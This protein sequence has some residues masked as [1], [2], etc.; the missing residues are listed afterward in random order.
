MNTTNPKKPLFKKVL[1][2]TI[3]TVLVLLVVLI[4]VPFLFKDKIVEMVKS[5]ANNNINA[6][7]TFNET[8]L[9]LLRNF[10]NASLRINNLA[11]INKAPF[12]GDTLFYSEKLDLNLKITE[13]FKSASETLAINSLGVT[14]SIVNIN[15]NKE[16]IGNY[17]IAKKTN[18]TITK[19]QQNTF[20]LNIN[21]YK[22]NNLKFTYYDS[23]SKMRLKIDSIYHSGKGNFAQD[24]LDLDTK[25]KAKVSFDME[26]TNYLNNVSVK[27]DALLGL[28]LKNAKYTFKEN[29]G[30]INKLPLEFHGFIQLIEE[31]QLYDI[32]FN[33]P[34]SS[35]KNLLGLL[36]KEYANNLSSV[37]TTGN[38]DLKGIVKGTLTK[39]T[40]PT[41]AISFDAKNASFKYDDLP[42]AVNNINLTAKIINETG[43]TKDTYINIKNSTF[44]ID[45]DTFSANGKIANFTTNPFINLNAKGTINLK[46]I[47]QVYPVAIKNQLDGILKADIATAFDMNSVDKGNYQNIKNKGLISLN[48]FKYEDKDV[49]NA[50]F[51]ENTTISFNSKTINL[52]KFIAKTGSSDL[53]INGKLDNFYG[54]LFKDQLLEGNFKLAANTIKIDDFLTDENDANEN[55]TSQTTQKLKIPSFLDIA[56]NAQAKSVIYDNI[57]LQNVSG[58]LFIKDEAVRLENIKSNVFDGEIGFS[59]NVSTKQEQPTF[60]MSLDLNKINIKESF[61]NIEMLK[62]IAPIAESIGGKIN[63]NINV[64]GSLGEH[65]AP[66]LQTISGDLFGKLLDPKLK[67]N[68]SK[69]LNLVSNKI[70]FINTEELDLNGINA[71]LTFNNGR[72]NITPFNFNYKDIGINIGGNHSFNNEMNYDLTLNI[73]VKYL[74]NSVTSVLAKLNPKD[75][76]EIKSIPVKASLTGSFSKPNFNSNIKK[77]TSDLVQQLIAKQKA[78]LVDKGTNKLINILGGTKDKAKDSTKTKDTKDTKEAIKEI[79]KDKVKNVLNG[80]FSKKKKDTVN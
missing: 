13:L 12:T 4:S 6:T 7:L 10:P 52:E 80:L 1:K 29:V 14:N 44:K 71:L 75:A 66:N 64:A 20:S 48:N 21:A 68:Q 28:D 2:F 49:A 33:T 70:N 58:K 37:K 25:T 63:S 76:N 35:F 62:S 30:Y 23:N 73:P 11:I 24:I 55:A 36:P 26:N 38:F 46:N 18:D 56:L 79:T 78:S 72:V 57:T 50:F 74:G 15:F 77:A 19:E 42:K 43:F 34:T 54:F 9:S 32:D 53:N 31:N 60:K 5:T 69:V 59:G 61:T 16:N 65:M 51:I 47:S 39:N 27:L 40:I 45:E 67:P 3:I 8:D 17:D 22:A 41:L